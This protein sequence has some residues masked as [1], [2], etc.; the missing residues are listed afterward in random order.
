MGEQEVQE[1][2]FF[3]TFGRVF[4]ASGTLNFFGDGWPYHKVY[5][6]LFGEEF[7]FHGAT[8]ISKTT[9]YSS[10]IGN[11]FLKDNLQPSQY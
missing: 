6:K 7:D 2:A 5:K 9:T 11:M 8:F 4:T 10:R 3:E 1:K